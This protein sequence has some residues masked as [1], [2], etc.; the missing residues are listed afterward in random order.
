MMVELRAWDRGVDR[1]DDII[2]EEHQGRTAVEDRG[3][4]RLRISDWTAVD[5]RDAGLDAPVA[6]RVVGWAVEDVIGGETDVVDGDGAKRDESA[7]V[8][9]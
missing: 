9:G 6:S 8:R 1:L 5:G 2:R 4:V 3:V 7:D